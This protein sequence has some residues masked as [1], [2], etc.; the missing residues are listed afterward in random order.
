MPLSEASDGRRPLTAQALCHGFS[1]KR[2][3]RRSDDQMSARLSID[4]L[5]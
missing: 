1:A 2:S 4:E 5:G 3:R